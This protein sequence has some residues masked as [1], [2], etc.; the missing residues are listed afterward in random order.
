MQLNIV[1][2]AVLEPLRKRNRG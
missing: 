2:W 1:V